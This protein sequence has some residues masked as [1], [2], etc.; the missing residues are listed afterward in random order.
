MVKEEKR[1]IA[2]NALLGE[3]GKAL[4]YLKGIKVCGE[5]D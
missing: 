5:V 1:E 2:L 4:Q 3:I